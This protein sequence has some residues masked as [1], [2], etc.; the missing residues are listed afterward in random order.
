MNNYTKLS[1]VE[2]LPHGKSH[3][4]CDLSPDFYEPLISSQESNL[5]LL[6][7]KK[8]GKKLFNAMFSL[9]FKDPDYL[10][11][12][13]SLN[14]ALQ[15]GSVCHD[16]FDS[17]SDYLDSFKLLN[18]VEFGTLQFDGE[19]FVHFNKFRQIPDD[20]FDNLKKMF[21][22]Y[23][24]NRF[25]KNL[26]SSDLKQKEFDMDEVKNGLALLETYRC[27]VIESEPSLYS[28]FTEKFSSDLEN[29]LSNLL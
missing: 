11:K 27:K 24:H 23:G 18:S 1:I 19:S 20:N 25:N 28:Q 26:F 3:E 14:V 9:D 12:I 17:Y 2:S 10:S 7:L 22:L 29:E 6:E 5:Y 8:K 21:E 15:L 13:E 4:I 16:D